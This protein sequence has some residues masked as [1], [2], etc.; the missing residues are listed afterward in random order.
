MYVFTNSDAKKLLYFFKYWVYFRI[1]P[2]KFEDI[3]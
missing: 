1:I 2:F 3:V